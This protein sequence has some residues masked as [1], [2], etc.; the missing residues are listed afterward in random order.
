MPTI[1]CLSPQVKKDVL[2]VLMDGGATPQMLKQ[3]EKLDVCNDGKA[4]AFGR[5]KGGGTGRAPTARNKFIGQCISEASKKANH[6]AVPDLMRACSR[7]W[8]EGPG[9]K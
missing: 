4:I 2:A 5:G 3:A 1:K 8:K 7:Q 9:K 6:P